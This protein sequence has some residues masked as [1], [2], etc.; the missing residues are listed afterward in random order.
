MPLEKN[1]GWVAKNAGVCVFLAGLVW[2]DMKITAQDAPA[3]V[4]VEKN[5]E[6]PK[7]IEFE[8]VKE[9]RLSL[10]DLG[11]I[12]LEGV[13]VYRVHIKNPVG[14]PAKLVSLKGSCNCTKVRLIS[15]QSIDTEN[16]V[17]CEIAIESKGKQ[18]EKGVELYLEFAPS[19]AI[20][21][22]STPLKLWRI[23]CPLRLFASDVGGFN[24]Q[25][26]LIELDPKVEQTAQ[27]TA[28]NFSN[29]EWHGASVEIRS[30]D[31][32]DS[33]QI[34]GSV[35]GF[36]V[37]E[38]P[39]QSVTFALPQGLRDRILNERFQGA[40]DL[41]ASQ[42]ESPLERLVGKAV[43]TGARI[44]AIR[45]LPAL[46]ALDIAD[47]VTTIHVVSPNT[48][49]VL[50]GARFSISAKENGIEI[51]PMEVVKKQDAWMT[52][53]LDT[54]KLLDA[55]DEKLS[56]RIEF[57]DGSVTELPLRMLK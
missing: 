36:E 22:K 30:V 48:S 55:R 44:E 1:C 5:E 16:S 38:F 13:R 28:F 35:A 56:V 57:G 41:F 43:F 52:I 2:A 34:V 8:I 39:S 7:T 20:E 33:W 54:A 26:V 10:T 51:A 4:D 42:K 37:S 19:V 14:E 31:G 9:T 40:V 6:A 45:V 3:R 24:N 49:V 12:P 53:K 15:D 17:C 32:K 50:T 11:I 27:F 25:E 46:L 23:I 21:N 29:H 47:P 18:G